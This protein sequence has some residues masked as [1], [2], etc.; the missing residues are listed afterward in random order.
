MTEKT[1]KEIHFDFIFYINIKYG[2]FLRISKYTF[3]MTI[4]KSIDNFTLVIPFFIFFLLRRS[5]S[6]KQS[7]FPEKKNDKKTELFV[8]TVSF[9]LNIQSKCN[10][11]TFSIKIV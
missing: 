3:M 11:S 9:Q 1:K 5:Y 7:L 10:F 6:L 4:L 8:S 2:R